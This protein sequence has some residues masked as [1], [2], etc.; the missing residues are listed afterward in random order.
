MLLKRT[1]VGRFALS[2]IC[3]HLIRLAAFNSPA[4]RENRY[5]YT[6]LDR[7][8]YL[9]YLLNSLLTAW[10]ALTAFFILSKAF[11]FQDRFPLFLIQIIVILLSS[12]SWSRRGLVRSVLAYYT[13]KPGFV[14]QV[15]HQKWNKKKKIFLRRLPLCRFLAKTLRVNKAAMKKYL[16]K[17]VVRSRR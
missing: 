11:S 17:S 8:Q 6:V 16:K 10:Y 1:D 7:F 9:H 15:S 14:S 2:Y 4:K 5:N 13:Q 3:L 12:G